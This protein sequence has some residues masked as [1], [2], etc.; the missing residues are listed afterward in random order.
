MSAMPF[1]VVIPARYASTRLPGKPLA[2]LGG[3]PMIQRVYERARRSAAGEVVVAT[4]DARIVDAVMAFGGAVALT[5][6]EHP[7]GTDRACEVA[8]LRGWD[9]D[10]LVVNV[11]GDEPLLP[12]AVVD[13]VAVLL[14][15]HSDAAAAT[16]AEPVTDA[17]TLFTASAVKVV[18][19]DSGRALMFS[20]APIP[21]HRDG[22]ADGPPATLPAEGRWRRHIGIYAYRV[23]T[24]ERFVSLPPAALERIESLEQLRLLANDLPMYVEDA[25][26]PVPPGIDT[27]D[28]LARVRAL[29]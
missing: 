7:S 8:R 6:P 5:A 9:S 11:Q 26:Q 13:Q 18:A 27:P 10:T 29:F 14:A 17:S 3:A 20:R 15:S 12:P 4:D 23:S 16:L 1:H 21:W 19:S 28:D 25:C 22:F 24:L 2:D